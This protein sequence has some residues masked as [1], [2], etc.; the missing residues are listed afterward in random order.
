MTIPP[1]YSKYARYYD[2]IYK[3]YLEE[4]VPRIIDFVVEIFKM[5][6]EREVRDVLDVACGTGGPTLELA[7][8]GF[9]VVGIDIS[10]YMIEIAKEKARRMN[11]DVKFEVGDM[12][13]L[14]FESEFD[15]VTCFF[16]SINYN[17]T[18]D[19]M[20]KAMKSFY[21]CLRK[22]GV[23]VADAPNPFRANTWL[24]GEPSIWRIDEDEV[25]ILVIDVVVMSS[26]SAEVDWN[27]T[28]IISE[29]GRLKMVADRHKLRAYTANELKLYAKIAGFRRARVY[30][31]LRITEKEPREARR[32]FI[33][34]VK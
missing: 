6:A 16:T 29:K 9:N 17:M 25:S 1:L 5:D 2:I 34:A 4:R 19:D 21:R 14:K 28:L 10:P 7:R 20:T 15:A 23:F 31:D 30:G 24:R 22:G 13:N 33:V 11:L 8:R 26:V 32:L 12:R 18:D 27:R 3:R